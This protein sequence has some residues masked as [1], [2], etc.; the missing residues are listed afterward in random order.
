MPPKVFRRPQSV[1]VFL[2]TRLNGR[3]SYLLFHR[4]PRPDLA[5]PAFWQG[6]SGAL[7]LEESFAQ[8]AVREVAE[9]SSIAVP[10][11]CSAD[12][13]QSFPIKPEWRG[14]YGEGPVA[15]EE[16]VFYALLPSAVEPVLS[17][18]H[19]SWRWCSFQ[20][21]HSLLEF[22]KNR[23]CLEAVEYALTHSAA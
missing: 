20:E 2:A 14:A 8:A 13:A 11:V 3:F 15:V 22:G 16:R 9:E 12:F 5:L 7:E 1:Q 23:Q 19:Q 21:A 4:R 18:E 17:E 10:Q 6:I